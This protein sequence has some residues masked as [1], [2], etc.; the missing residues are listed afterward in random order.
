MPQALSPALIARIKRAAL[1]QRPASPARARISRMRAATLVP[2]ARYAHP[3]G[4]AG[5][6]ELALLSARL[7]A[8]AG[9]APVQAAA[10]SSLLTGSGV[11]PKIYPGK[12]TNSIPSPGDSGVQGAGC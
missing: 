1:L 3:G 9:A 12:R 5:L 2:G 11:E 10:L 7:A 6:P 4:Y 8:G